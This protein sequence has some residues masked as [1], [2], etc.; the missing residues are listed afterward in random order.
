[1]AEKMTNSDVQHVQAALIVTVHAVKNLTASG[2]HKNAC[3][4]I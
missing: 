4:P 1:M 3:V 2:G